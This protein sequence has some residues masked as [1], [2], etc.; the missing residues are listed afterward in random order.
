MVL[1]DEQLS[2]YL[3]QQKPDNTE[4]EG[5]IV[6]ERQGLYGKFHQ[7]IEKVADI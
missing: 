6:M 5:W 2:K 4:K 1:T 3:R 7:K